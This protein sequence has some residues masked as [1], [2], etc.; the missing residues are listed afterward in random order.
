MG[1][2][3]TIFAF[4]RDAK[5]LDRLKSNAAATGATIIKAQ[6]VGA[7]HASCELCYWAV[8][9]V[10]EAPFAIFTLVR[11]T[12]YVCQIPAQSQAQ[13]AMVATISL[14]KQNG[15]I[16]ADCVCDHT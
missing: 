14:L 3:G 8:S 11:Q 7:L 1:G 4:D 5:R 10:Q 15:M 6:Q 13:Q 12:L 16:N 9:Q 2:R